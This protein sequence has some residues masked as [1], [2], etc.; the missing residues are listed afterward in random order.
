MARNPRNSRAGSG[1]VFLSDL[2]GN[3]ARFFLGV[4]F[5]DFP[6]YFGVFQSSIRLRF[7]LGRFFATNSESGVRSFGGFV[8]SLAHV[9]RPKSGGK[10]SSPF[11]SLAFSEFYFCYGAF[12]RRVLG[13]DLRDLC[14]VCFRWFRARVFV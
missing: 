4:F 9:L 6:S 14:W 12:L 11:L 8:R 13:I 1:A 5:G 2:G 7:F 3:A 10:K